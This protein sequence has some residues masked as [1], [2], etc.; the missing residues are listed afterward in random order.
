LGELDIPLDQS[1][2]V[3][4]VGVCCHG[5]SYPREDKGGC[6]GSEIRRTSSDRAGIGWISKAKTSRCPA[7]YTQQAIKRASLKLGPGFVMAVLCS[8]MSR[9][10]CTLALGAQIN[11]SHL[12]D[13]SVLG[14]DPFKRSQRTVTVVH[15]ITPKAQYRCYGVDILEW[16]TGTLGNEEDRLNRGIYTKPN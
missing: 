1:G 8:R 10:V 6:S 2:K 12:N 4:H 14:T 16:L 3:V 11:T 9:E 15:I 5:C 7:L 13:S